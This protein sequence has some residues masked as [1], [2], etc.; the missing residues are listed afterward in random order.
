[1]GIYLRKGCLSWWE[2]L[3]QKGVG[4][5]GNHAPRWLQY[6]S[7]FRLRQLLYRSLIS[8]SRW[9]LYGSLWLETNELLLCVDYNRAGKWCRRIWLGWTIDWG[10]YN[11]GIWEWMLYGVD[12]K[13]VWGF[14]VWGL[15][16]V[17]WKF[18]ILMIQG[19]LFVISVGEI[20]YWLEED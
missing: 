3:D 19:L 20:L 11:I 17:G 15:S 10:D 12:W 6:R 13:L 4:F 9:W 8:A 16:I 18:D 5:E 2:I 1:M 14:L 7:L